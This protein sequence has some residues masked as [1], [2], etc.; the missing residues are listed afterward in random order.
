MQPES[1]RV[2]LSI[3]RLACRIMSLTYS[4][5]QQT[6][7]CMSNILLSQSGQPET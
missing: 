2:G 6:S 5:T 7:L 3:S 1:L 4:R